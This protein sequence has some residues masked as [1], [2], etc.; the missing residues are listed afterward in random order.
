MAVLNEDT[1]YGAENSRRLRENF[2]KVGAQVVADER[3]AQNDKGFRSQL[4]RL[5]AGHPDLLIYPSLFLEQSLE[6]TKEISQIVQGP[7]IPNMVVG[8]ACLQTFDTVSYPAN[9]F[10]LNET[11]G[12]DQTA[13]RTMQDFITGYRQRNSTMPTPFVAAGHASV[14]VVKTALQKGGVTG[15][16]IKSALHS[17]DDETALGRVKFD[18]TGGNTGIGYSLY[19][20]KGKQLVLAQ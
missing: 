19:Q 14:N 3:F 4:A 8:T 13:N 2:A 9:V 18:S 20:L 12:T 11:F 6:I 15:A 17:V 5:F 10:F 1:K 7:S 16:Q